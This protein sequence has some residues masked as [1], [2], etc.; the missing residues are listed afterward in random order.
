MQNPTG[1]GFGGPPCRGDVLARPEPTPP[2]S[3]PELGVTL[4]E[5]MVAL[6]IFIAIAGAVLLVWQQSQ[7]AYFHGAG[8]A[9][10]QQNARAAVEHMVREIRQAQSITTGEGTRI[11]FT[12][13]R[14]TSSRTYALSASASPGY[15][16][17]LLYTKAPECAAPCPIADYLV[18]GG[19]TFAYLDAA[20]T[21]LPTPLSAAD[22]I[23]V[24]EVDIRVRAQTTV[25]DAEPAQQLESSARLRNR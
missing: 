3:E 12:S 21:V 5:L 24:A 6:A 19:L 18:A 1:D 15:R 22:R 17:S 16:Y 14:D 23:R 10:I 7:Q 8:A 2:E 25:A 20:R 11:I 13:V 9:E 4:V